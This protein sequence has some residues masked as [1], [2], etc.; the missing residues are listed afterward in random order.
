MKDIF[1]IFLLSVTA[2]AGLPS[3]TTT[4]PLISETARAA[5]TITIAAHNSSASSKASARFVAS[6]HGDQNV[7]NQAIALLPE[8]GGSVTLLEGDYDIRAV[9]STKGGILLNKSNVILRGTGAA[10]HLRL[11]DNQNVNIIF[12]NGPGIEKCFGSKPQYRRQLE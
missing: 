8:S 4:E 10:T 7:I 6:G 3:R 2:W 5:S 1:P 11:A 9:A 12:V